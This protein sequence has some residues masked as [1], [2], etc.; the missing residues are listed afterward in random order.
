MLKFSGSPCSTS[1]SELELFQQHLCLAVLPQRALH[2]A[3]KPLHYHSFRSRYLLFETTIEEALK[4]A[5]PKA[6]PRGTF[7]V[8]KSNDSQKFASH[9]AYRSL[10]RPSSLQDPRHPSLSVIRVIKRSDIVQLSQGNWP[11]AF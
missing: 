5:Y 11:T 10:L 8:Q 9:A 1:G 6:E 3:K 7:R 2:R 4:W